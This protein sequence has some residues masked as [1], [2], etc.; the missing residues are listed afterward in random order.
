MS[1]CTSCAL[2]VCSTPTSTGGMN[3]SLQ[4]VW[5]SWQ[6]KMEVYRRSA[7]PRSIATVTMLYS[8]SNSSVIALVFYITP[9]GLGECNFGDCYD[10]AAHPPTCIALQSWGIPKPAICVLLNTMQTMQYVLETG[11][12]E[13]S[14]S[15]GG[16][17][18]APNS[19][20][21]QG[22]G[23]SSLGFMALS[24]LIVNAYRQMG[25]GA[26]VVSSFSQSDISRLERYRTD[27]LLAC[28]TKVRC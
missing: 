18:T 11:F 23:A 15:Y 17:A 8:Q 6:Y 14:S 19:G 28:L 10:Q 25:H 21:G 7:T 9:P 22:S 20:L 1:S 13:S 16:T 26:Q 4:N 24:S 12:R 5:C 2:F 27:V 3:W